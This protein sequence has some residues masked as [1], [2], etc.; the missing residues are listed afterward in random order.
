MGKDL[1]EKKEKN[2][3]ALTVTNLV[4]LQLDK[5]KERR[6]REVQMKMSWSKFFQFVASEMEKFAS[7]GKHK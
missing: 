7:N 5:L 3:T 1:V 2:W 6:E 4:K